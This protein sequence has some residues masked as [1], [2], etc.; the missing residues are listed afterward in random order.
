MGAYIVRRLIQSAVLVFLVASFMAIFIQLLPGDPAYTILG[1]KANPDS[2]AAVR[3]KL[4]LNRPI[5]VQYV[6]WISHVARGDFGE[7][8][9]SDRPILNDLAKRLPRT[10]ELIVA[11]L[12]LAILVGIPAGVVAA[13]YRNRLPDVLVSLVSLLGVSTPVFVSGTLLLLVF[14]VRWQI[15]PATGYVSITDSPLGH[16]KHL[17]MPAVTLALLEAAVILRMTRSSLLEVLGE[18]YVRTARAKG[19]G[20]R[21]VLYQHALRNALIPVVTIIGIQAGTLLGGTVIVEYIFNWPGIS[22][23]LLAA[24]NQ[25]DY[26]VIQAIIV[27]IATLFV[28]LNLATDLI[29]AA[30]DPRIKYG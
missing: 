14:G 29:Y 17:L 16:L 4:G 24:I 28:L 12:V 25:R 22:T 10:I 2:I 6:D 26:P 3:E 1:D 8:L 23:Y 15:L 5:Y 19:L 27:I 20:Q 30:I 11:S 18:D 9:I 7:S 21:V 13:S